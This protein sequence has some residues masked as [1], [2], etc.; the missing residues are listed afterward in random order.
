MIALRLMVERGE[1]SSVAFERLR[2]LRPGAVE[3]DAQR[4]W[5]EAVA[6]TRQATA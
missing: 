2:A 5:A 3:T 4:A 1:A 6:T